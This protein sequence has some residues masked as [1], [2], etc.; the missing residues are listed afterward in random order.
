M[1]YTRNKIRHK[2]IPWIE[3]NINSKVVEKLYNTSVIFRETDIVMKEIAKRRIVQATLRK[4]RK[5]ISLSLPIIKRIQSVIR[6]YIYRE[7]YKQISGTEKDFYQNNFNE[8]ESILNASGSKQIMLAHNVIVLKEY[9][10]LIFLKKG[11]FVV[12]DINFKRVISNVRARFGFENYRIYMRKIK[13]LPRKRNQFE[14]KNIAYLDY[15]KVVFPITLRHRRDGDKFIPLGMKGNKKL[16]DFFI[17]EKVP[18]FERDNI[19]IFEDKE[20]II[21][22]GGKRIDSRVS[23]TNKTKN[24][25][26]LRMEEITFHKSR[27]A[28]RI[29]K[30]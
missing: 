26:Q 10:N 14:N 21:W 25:L 30:R 6:F 15:D 2:I 13:I 11:S 16:Q 5:G 17:D 3:D 1:E 4:H 9:D 12:S 19:I 22:I 24:I 20:K 8:I 27:H 29:K 7:I 18:K 28:E 23:I